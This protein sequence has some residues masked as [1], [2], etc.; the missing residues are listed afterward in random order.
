[1]LKEN[2]SEL[3]LEEGITMEQEIE[4]EVDGVAVNLRHVVWVRE[5]L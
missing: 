4:R 3:E 2:V 1:M 5:A